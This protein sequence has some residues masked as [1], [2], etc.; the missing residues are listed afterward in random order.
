MYI[1]YANLGSCTISISMKGICRKSNSENKIIEKYR[2][3]N[4]TKNHEI[5]KRIENYEKNLK[6]L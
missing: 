4:K 6:L 2:M 3:I 1:N 5:I